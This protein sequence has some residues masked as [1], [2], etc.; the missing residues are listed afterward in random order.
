[1]LRFALS[2]S[3]SVGLALSLAALAAG[4]MDEPVQSQHS[5]EEVL[6]GTPDW[7]STF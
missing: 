6:P 5:S 4:A 3:C 2:R 1:M 7:L